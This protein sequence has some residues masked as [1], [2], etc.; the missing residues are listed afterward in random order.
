MNSINKNSIIVLP[1][2]WLDKI[3]RK[4]QLYRHRNM[5]KEII[6]KLF[7]KSVQI[8]MREVVEDEYLEI[9]DI[10]AY[11]YYTLKILFLCLASL[12]KFYQALF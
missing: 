8:E 5:N 4:L 11:I 7:R 1:L 10:V 12:L 3:S 2:I 6:L 9:K